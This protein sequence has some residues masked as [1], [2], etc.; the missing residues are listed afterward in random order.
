MT[1]INSFVFSVDVHTLVDVPMVEI[2]SAT[3]NVVTGGS[4]GAKEV[5]RVEGTIVESV[6]MIV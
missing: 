4:V 6:G 3:G 2:V 5:S 1:L